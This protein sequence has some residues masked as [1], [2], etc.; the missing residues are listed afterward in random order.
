LIT[1]GTAK[2]EEKSNEFWFPVEVNKAGAIQKY[3]LCFGDYTTN[4]YD[5]YQLV[6]LIPEVDANFRLFL[7]VFTF[8]LAFCCKSFCGEVFYIQACHET[9]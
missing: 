3:L 4:Y 9:S 2:I 7:T 8:R 1:A 6:I 5:W